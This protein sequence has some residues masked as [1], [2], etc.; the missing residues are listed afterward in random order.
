[1]A[2]PRPSG[3]LALLAI[4][5]G[6]S[7]CGAGPLERESRTA[8]P[9][10]AT[11]AST[12]APKARPAALRL[13]RVGGFSSPLYVTAPPGDRTHL[14]VVE[15]GGSIQVLRNGRRLSRPFLDISDEVR[16]G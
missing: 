10:V 3:L 16:S 12:P 13:I 2:D 1:M 8:A 6:L 4:V 5:A 15:Q 7:A 11:S 14:F 9:P